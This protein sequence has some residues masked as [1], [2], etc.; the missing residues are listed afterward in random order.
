MANTLAIPLAFLAISAILLWCVID[1]KRH[2][3]WKL[4]LIIAVPMSCLLIWRSVES[5]RGW[6]TTEP[7]PQKF[8][9]LWNEV[10]EP[11]PKTG[12]EGAIY[13][14]AGNVETEEDEPRLYK[15][16]YSRKFH[17]QLESAN[18]AARR[19]GG[20]IVFERNNQNQGS[21]DDSESG[22]GERQGEGQGQGQGNNSGAGPDSQGE[23]KF[24]RLPPAKMPKKK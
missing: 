18:K 16:E 7:L 10:R 14:L 21:G 5:Y 15:V 1:T 19:G 3:F 6:P 13:V 11:D 2:W 9:L 4:I 17:E 12:S 22:E 24:Y 8:V 20:P 23:F